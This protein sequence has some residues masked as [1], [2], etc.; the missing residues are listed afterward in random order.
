M[1]AAPIA[2]LPFISFYLTALLF[3]LLS[4]G[5]DGAHARE[6][7]LRIDAMQYSFGQRSWTASLADDRRLVVRLA[8]ERR[9][10]ELSQSQVGKLR[11]TIAQE[12]FFELA[13]GYGQQEPGVD[14]RSITVT[15]DGRSKTVAVYATLGREERVEEL[16]RAL[17]VAITIR[18]LFEWPGA[19]DTR[20][21]DTRLLRSLVERR[22]TR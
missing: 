14:F 11:E 12:R 13:D 4:L 18:S 19:L 9:V 6:P 5:V 8:L 7:S 22:T 20:E 1:A 21:E 10:F 17:R 16:R 3:L 15:L 2:R